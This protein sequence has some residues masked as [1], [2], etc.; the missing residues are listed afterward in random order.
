MTAYP[1]LR[2]RP[3][4]TIESGASSRCELPARKI[5]LD[6][7]LERLETRYLQTT[8]P[9]ESEGRTEAEMY[10]NGDTTST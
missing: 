7:T 10:C 2:R 8:R 9:G 6:R 1:T 3:L 5:H 4:N